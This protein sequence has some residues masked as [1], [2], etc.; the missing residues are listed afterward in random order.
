[1]KTI[2][3]FLF[4][5]LFIVIITVS[6]SAYKIETFSNLSDFMA[7]PQVPDDTTA[8]NYCRSVKKWRVDHLSH[9]QKRVLYTMR[10]LQ[11]KQ[12]SANNKVFPFKNGVVI[13]RQHLPIYNRNS[14]DP[15]TLTVHP[16]TVDIVHWIKSNNI[17]D[18]VAEPIPR[19]DPVSIVITEENDTPEGLYVDMT[20]MNFTDFKRLLS[21]LYELY[22]SEFL[23]EYKI[24][25]RTNN[26]LR[27]TL[28]PALRA[29]LNYLIEQ[30]TMWQNKRAALDRDQRSEP[31]RLCA[32]EISA[33]PGLK[34]EY[35][36]ANECW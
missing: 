2:K 10:A 3:G 20:K 25:V 29:E 36:K 32:Q 35:D 8:Y 5:L 30:T 15:A 23:R 1:M 6:M 13:P 14:D 4:L 11:S 7:F 12:F 9:Q 21:G 26:Y 24:L 22:D 18:P 33:N 16:P 19:S 27:D 28:I 17:K 34:A 31:E